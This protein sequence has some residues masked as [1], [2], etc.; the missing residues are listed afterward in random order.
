MQKKILIIDYTTHHPEVIGALATL[1]RAQ[2]VQLA[3]TARFREKYLA[4]GGDAALVA[5]IEPLVRGTDESDRSWLQRLGGVIG[6]QDIAIF[7]TPIKSPLLARTLELPTTARKVLFLHNVNYFLDLE[8]LDLATFA[9]L[10][11]PGRPALGQLPR[12]ALERLRQARK[13]RRQ[14]RA[15]AAFAD[16]NRHVDFYCAGSDSISR[17]FQQRSGQDNAVLLPTNAG[18]ATPPDFPSYEGRLHVAIVGIVAQERRDYRGL[19]TALTTAPLRRP[20]LLSLLGD[21]PDPAFGRELSALIARNSNPLLEVR[22]DPARG[23]IS[24][25]A[26][27]ELLREVHVL[28]SPIQPDTEFRLHR[29]VYGTSKISGVEGDCLALGR[30]LLLPRSYVCDSHIE[31]LAIHYADMRE[32]PAALDA[33]GDAAALEICYERLRC[34]IAANFHAEL[35]T[36]FLERVLAR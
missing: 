30:P 32:L 29:E 2:R 21:C 17:Y 1:F 10:R 19:L 9:R 8:R 27:R 11:A 12:F 5:A 36:T 15:G 4:P 22:F 20:L 35:A 7:S 33:L 25:D 16:L 34:A 14:Q 18:A 3:V 28:L 13:R 6:D 23:Y 26:L 24:A 31:P